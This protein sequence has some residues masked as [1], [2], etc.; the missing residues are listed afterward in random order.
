MIN[1]KQLVECVI[2]PALDDLQL[3]SEDA[4]ELLLFTCANESLGGTYLHQIKG[5]ALGIYQME[6]VTYNDLWQNYI[7]QQ[8]SMCLRLIYHFNAPQMSD[9]IRLTYDLRYATAMTRLYYARISEKLP[10]KNDADAIW[11]YYKKYYNTEKGTAEY[12]LAMNN[13]YRFID[14]TSRLLQNAH[15]EF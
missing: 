11:N 6:P 4:V 13:Y 14:S 2:K 15:T 7:A 3:Y 9:E 1:A 10:D 5:P 8:K 12:H